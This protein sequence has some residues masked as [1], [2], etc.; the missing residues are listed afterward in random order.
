M[1]FSAHSCT[2]VPVVEISTI[3]SDSNSVFDTVA[4]FAFRNI[5]KYVFTHNAIFI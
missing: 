1:L 4:M 3:L 5:T 2:E